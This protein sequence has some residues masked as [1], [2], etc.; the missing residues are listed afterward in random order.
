M[1]KLTDRPSSSSGGGFGQR[2]SN[3]PP[4]RRVSLKPDTAS[5]LRSILANDVLKIVEIM[6]QSPHLIGIFALDVVV[7]LQVL[8][9]RKYPMV[10]ILKPRKGMHVM[11]TR[12]FLEVHAMSHVFLVDPF[13]LD[14]FVR[15]TK[16]PWAAQFMAKIPRVYVGTQ[17]EC[18]KMVSDC[19]RVCHETFHAHYMDV[20]PHRA[21]GVFLKNMD[22]VEDTVLMEACERLFERFQTTEMMLVDDQCDGWSD[23][24]DADDHDEPH[25][26]DDD[27]DDARS[28]G[29]RS[30]SSSSSVSSDAD[31]MWRLG[32]G[33]ETRRIRPVD[34]DRWWSMLGPFCEWCA[35]HH[36]ETPSSSPSSKGPIAKAPE[37]DASWQH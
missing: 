20:P 31:D 19:A 2:R 12:R 6:S 22:G 29:V 1:S 25:E 17:T 11:V 35:D 23:D 14:M 36:H 26:Y 34:I 24:E 8:L 10:R 32:K 7:C 30:C 16:D 3:V 5:S 9:R 21:T 13:F 15:S 28:V 18:V 37:H 33:G 4:G 27:E